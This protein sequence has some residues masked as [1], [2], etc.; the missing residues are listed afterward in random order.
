MSILLLQSRPFK[1]RPH[2]RLQPSQFVAIPIDKLSRFGQRRMDLLDLAPHLLADETVIGM[3][4]G[5][6]AQLAH[7]QRFTQIHFHVP[8]NLKGERHHVL[9]FAL[10]IFVNLLVQLGRAFHAFLKLGFKTGFLNLWRRVV[11][12]DRREV[13]ALLSENSMPVQIAIESEIAE[14]VEGI[15]GIL[16]GAT[17]LVAAVPAPGKLLLQDPS[18]L[19]GI[20]PGNDLS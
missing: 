5:H 20:H 19:G 13:L 9:R 12:V 17:E 1:F 8:A 3:P 14:N 15:I 6:G 4:L 16:E 18:L 10:Q 11:A 2:L 7:V